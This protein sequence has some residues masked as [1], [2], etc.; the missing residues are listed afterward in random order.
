MS[1]SQVSYVNQTLISSNGSIDIV[2]DN[3]G[4]TDLTVV[5]GGSG[6]NVTVSD[7]A[8]ASPSNGALW[9]DSNQGALKL[10]YQDQDSAQWVDASSILV[11]SNGS[12]GGGGGGGNEN[13]NID[14]GLPNSL[15]GGV[16]P[17]DAGGV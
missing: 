12:S 11:F 14:G 6:S 13:V 9:W 4:N 8:P 3:V 10:Y 1:V 5:G 7:T 15:Y 2:L 17:I 16:S